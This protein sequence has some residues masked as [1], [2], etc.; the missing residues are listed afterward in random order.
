MSRSGLSQNKVLSHCFIV[1]SP[2]ISVEKNKILSYGIELDIFAE[3]G[4]VA[5]I[6]TTERLR[7]TIGDTD[8]IKT[9]FTYSCHPR[10]GE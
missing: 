8:S 1:F 3:K 7:L 10:L 6:F 5:Y 9:R 4:N 2:I